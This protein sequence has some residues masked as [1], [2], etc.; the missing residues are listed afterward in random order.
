[1]QF[2]AKVREVGSSNIITIP[3]NVMESLELENGKIY[4]FSVEKNKSE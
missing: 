4:Q 3:K 2:V 1:M